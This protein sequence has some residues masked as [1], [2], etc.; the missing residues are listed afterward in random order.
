[1]RGWTIG[2]TVLIGVLAGPTA[3]ADPCETLSLRVLAVNQ[4]GVLDVTLRE[5][6]LRATRIFSVF[7][8]ALLWTNTKPAES[9]YEAAAQMRIVIVPD[10]R[11]E[12]DRRRLG[13]AHTDNMAAYAFYSRVA[14]LAEHNGVD[15]AALLGHVIAHEMG[16]L[17]LP[18]NSHSSRGVMRAEW[19]RTQ[20]DDMTKGLLTFTP[21]QVQ[22]IRSRVRAMLTGTPKVKPAAGEPGEVHTLRILVLNEA[23]VPQAERHQIELAIVLGHVLA[24]EMGHLLL[25]HRP[26]PSNGIMRARWDRAHDLAILRSTSG[27]SFTTEEGELIR[28][29]IDDVC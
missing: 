3:E 25:A 13:T 2:L 29:T 17:L 26:H 1:M 22:L 5:A 6:E 15:V 4:A 12:R 21:Q 8:I 23:A 16:H 19:D 9:Y 28:R 18:A 11:V 10:S 14:D 24:H 20:F 27:L 7:G